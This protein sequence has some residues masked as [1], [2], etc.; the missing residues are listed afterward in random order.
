MDMASTS[1]GSVRSWPP[2]TTILLVDDEKQVTRGLC[3]ILHGTGLVTLQARHR[4]NT[5]CMTQIGS[6]FGLIVAGR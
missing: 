3:A 5:P 6:F 4:S 1:E 2:G